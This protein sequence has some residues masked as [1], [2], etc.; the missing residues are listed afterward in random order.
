MTS[1]NVETPRPARAFATPRRAVATPVATTY[2]GFYLRNSL[3]CTGAV[4][5]PGPFDLCPDVIQSPTIVGDPQATFSTPASWSTAYAT[6]PDLGQ[7]NYYYVRGLNGLAEQVKTQL[8]LYW[9]PAQLIL[10]PASWQNNKL[11]TASGRQTVSVSAGAGAIGVGGEPFVW[12]PGAPSGSDFYALVAQAVDTGGT[13]PIPTITSW[14]DMAALLT[15]DL[16]FGFNNTRY[17][18]PDAATW[19]SY[20]GLSVPPSLPS[21]GQVLISLSSTGFSGGTVGILANQFGSNQQ[22]IVLAPTALGPGQLSGITVTL[23]PGFSATFTVEYWAGTGTAPAAGASINVTAYYVIPPSEAASA[24]TAGLVDGVR[25]RF[26]QERLGVGPT[27]MAVLG[28]ASFVVAT[29]TP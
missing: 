14:L 22:P 2:P 6:Q 18:D 29:P 9:A 8:S 11:S 28:S 7:A 20:L 23:D 4:P 27:Q 25:N 1:M 16:G 24:A 10:F 5:S 21:S 26:L 13:N 3:G 17:I 19:S 12:T 15:Q